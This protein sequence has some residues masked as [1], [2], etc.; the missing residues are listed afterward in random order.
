[1]PITLGC[2]SCGKRFRAR[3]ESAGKKVKCPYCQAAVSVPTAEESATAG[4][5]TAPLPPPPGSSMSPAVPP[6][7]PAPPRPLPPPPAPVV[8][9][10]DDWGALPTGPKPSAPPAPPPP[11]PSTG[12][13][14]PNP[15][16]FPPAYAGTAGRGTKERP[17]PAKAPGKP[18]GKAGE[19]TP[20]Q[21]LADGWRKVRRGL[22]WVQFALFFLA[23][24]GFVEFGKTVAARTGTELPTGEGQ[25][26][27]EG[28]INSGANSV[29][30][31][32]TDEL[33]LL[34][35]GLPVVLAG[36]LAVFGRVIAGGAPRSSGARGMF[37][38]S[39]LFLL[40]GLAGLI[41]S[42]CFDRLLM[43]DEYRYAWTGVLLLVP[44]AEY[45]FL[46]ALTACGL[47]L[48]RPR[49]ARAVGLVGF[50]AALGAFA[51]LLGWD[52]YK[53]FGRP[54]VPDADILLYEQAA[55]MLGWLLLIGV[56]WRAVRNVR[57]AAQEFLDT[58]DEG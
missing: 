32:K 54:K 31:T 36:L 41:L 55:M 46:T 29:P 26:K 44:L 20:E 34:L 11:P 48:K 52:L 43:K 9:T 24:V 8:A 1:M 14:E 25:I 56:Y 47:A 7:R 27:I 51:G 2:P 40:V 22:F 13:T 45:W 5:P 19:E 58:V 23:L 49:T 15:V 33:N 4:A 3:D 21:I 30:L 38:L 37:A 42:V 53:Q 12:P 50:V 6:P 18:K 39:G 16:A 57:S 17:K 35:Y 10:P 28:Y